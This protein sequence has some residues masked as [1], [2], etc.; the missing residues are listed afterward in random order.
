MTRTTT[1]INNK[2]QAKRRYSSVCRSPPAPTKPSIE[3]ARAGKIDCLPLQ[4]LEVLIRRFLMDNPVRKVIRLFDFFRTVKNFADFGEGDFRTT[5]LNR[6][7]GWPSRHES[8]LS[9]AKT[10]RLYDRGKTTGDIDLD[11]GLSSQTIAQEFF[12]G[13]C[14]LEHF[15]AGNGGLNS[16]D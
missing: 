5:Q 11:I 9:M 13:L 15:I 14:F 1:K 16:D 2:T 3:E 8:D 10:Q 12:R 7:L 4:R 6:K